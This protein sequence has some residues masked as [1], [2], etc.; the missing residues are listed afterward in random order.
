MKI[1]Q[2]NVVYKDKSTGRTCYE[3][4]KTLEKKGYEGFVAYGRG[5]HD[6]ENSYRIGTEVEYYFHNIM[7][8]LTGFQGYFSVF[9]TRRLIKY[10]NK[11]TPDIIH[12][13]NL[14]S[15]YLNLPLLFKYLS[16]KHTSYT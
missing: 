3:V 8:R 14:H 12:L 16:K 6:D 4:V 13:R 1:L 5:K 10:I 9:A 2:I 15:N 7:S 11:I